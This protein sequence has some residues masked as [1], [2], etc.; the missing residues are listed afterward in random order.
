MSRREGLP[1]MMGH[2]NERTNREAVRKEWWVGVGGR[3]RKGGEIGQ[4]EDHGPR[5]APRGLNC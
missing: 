1:W 4:A 5:E 3:R 2:K